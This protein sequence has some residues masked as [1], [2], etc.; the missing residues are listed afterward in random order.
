MLDNEL[1]DIIKP[2]NIFASFRGTKTIE[3]LLIHSKIPILDI[4]PEDQEDTIEPNGICQPCSKGFCYV[5]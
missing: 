5:R 4:D 1:R 2:G 3:D